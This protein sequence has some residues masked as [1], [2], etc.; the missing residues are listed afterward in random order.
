VKT[1]GSEQFGATRF[2]TT[3]VGAT[4]RAILRW[5]VLVGLF[6]A[7]LSA[8]TYAINEY[9]AFPTFKEGGVYWCSLSDRTVTITACMHCPQDIGNPRY[10]SASRCMPRTNDP[11]WVA[12]LHGGV[13]AGRTFY[14]WLILR[15]LTAIT[16]LS[17]RGRSESVRVP[18]ASHT[19]AFFTGALLLAIVSRF[20][21]LAIGVVRYG[22]N[23]EWFHFESGFHRMITVWL[24]PF[25]HPQ[26]YSS[27][28]LSEV[29]MCL[30]LAAFWVFAVPALRTQR[31]P[32]SKRVLVR[33]VWCWLGLAA[34]VYLAMHLAYYFAMYVPIDFVAECRA[35]GAEYVPHGASCAGVVHHDD[36]AHARHMN[37]FLRVKRATL[38]FPALLIYLHAIGVFFARHLVR[39]I[40]EPIAT[41]AVHAE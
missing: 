15:V 16:P 39:W 5:F 8:L 6:G 19:R 10:R 11:L 33:S 4:M 20:A 37:S 13:I 21:D 1:S 18:A 28:A 9:G 23:A 2:T 24:E 30:G 41:G 38:V 40:E 14:L 27:S 29:V 12:L 26:F 36:Y 35:L 25:L 32:S 22:R 17:S 34:I 3:S 31:M 7:L